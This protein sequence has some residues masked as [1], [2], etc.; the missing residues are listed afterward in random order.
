MGV[1]FCYAVIERFFPV[2]LLVGVAEVLRFR[3]GDIA[4]VLL[5]ILY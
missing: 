2:C 4:M 1:I 3:L 5:K